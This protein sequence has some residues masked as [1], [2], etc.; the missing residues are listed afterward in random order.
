MLD[1]AVFNYFFFF[2][3][4]DGIRDGHVTGVQTCAL[5]ISLVALNGKIKL[6]DGAFRP[7]ELNQYLRGVT[8]KLS[9]VIRKLLAAQPEERYQDANTVRRELPRVPPGYR[10][11][12]ADGAPLDLVDTMPP[13]PEGAPGAQRPERPAGQVAPSSM[14]AIRAGRVQQGFSPP[15][16]SPG[17]ASPQTGPRWAAGASGDPGQ[18]LT[19][20]GRQGAARPSQPRSMTQAAASTI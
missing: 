9:A 10:L 19:A 5:P 8:P 1:P 3:A 20:A 17:L 16:S 15:T 7:D 11:T 18:P 2:Q 4:E 13:M 6:H 14:E 12:H